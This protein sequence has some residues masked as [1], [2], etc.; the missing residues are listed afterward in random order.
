[1]LKQMYMHFGNKELVVFYGW[2]TDNDL[3]FVF[4]CIGIFFISM[5]FEFIK[6]L[7]VYMVKKGFFNRIKNYRRSKSMSDSYDI[8]SAD[9]S[10]E[11][12]P[13]KS[14]TKKTYIK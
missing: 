8:K 3:T 14:K 10:E 12:S 4:T 7:R 9:S 5:L 13:K 1:M 2:K 6:F 11:S